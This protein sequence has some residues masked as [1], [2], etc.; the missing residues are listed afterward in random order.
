MANRLLNIVKTITGAVAAIGASMAAITTKVYNFGTNIIKTTEKLRGYNIA[1]YGMLKTQREVMDFLAI[2]NK[3]TRDMPLDYE[4]VQE[5][6]TGLALI[7]PVR[8]MLL[9]SKDLES[10]MRSLFQIVAGLAQL[11]PEWG[12][13]GAIFSLRNALTG[14][15]R[16]LQRRFE[17]PVRVIYSAEGK[18]LQNLLHDPEKMVET[19]ATYISTFYS[20]ETLAMT[21]RQF[22]MVVEKLKGIWFQFTTEIGNYGFYDTVI[23][24]LVSNLIGI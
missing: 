21:T 8:E 16:S 24:D 5:S 11:Q 14:D 4:T 17:L 10:T 2:A 19:L 22:G 23:N 12:A 9:T 1:L 18:S 6:I 15:L 20:D 13:K 7:A 3:V